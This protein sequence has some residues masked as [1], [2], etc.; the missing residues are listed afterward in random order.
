MTVAP[1]PPADT[2]WRKERR[3]FGELFDRFINSLLNW[4]FD[5]RPERAQRRMRNLFVLFLLTGFLICLYYY[6]P[7]LWAGYLQEVFSYLLN[8]N[9]AAAYAGEP[10]SK[11]FLFAFQAFTD[12][13]VFQYFPIILAPF[14]IALHLAALYLADIFELDDVAV[15]R[16]FVWEV[17]LSGSD[18][19]MRVRQGQVADE[20]R[21][22]SNYL[23]GGPGKVMVDLDSVALFERADGTPHVIGPTGKEPGGRATIEGFERFR[24][25]I[26]IRDHYVELRDQ[27]DRSKSVRGRSRDGIP[28]TAT[29]VRL[30]FSISRGENPQPSAEFPY[31]FAK[32]AIERIVYKSVSRVTPDQKEPSV[33]EF[34]WINN[35]IGLIRGRLSGFMSERNLTEYLASVGLPEIEKAK[36]REELIA[37]QVRRLT[38]PDEAP[39]VKPPEVPQFTPRHQ[40]TSLFSQFAEDFTKSAR[41]N[42]V[43]LHWIGVG[44]WKTP[45]EIDIVSEKHLQAWKLSQE[46]MKNGN[47]MTMN[48]AENQAMLEKME[49]LIHHVPIN[50]Y[51]EIVEAP[52]RQFYKKPLPKKFD[53]KQRDHDLDE[54][55]IFDDQ[56]MLDM[57]SGNYALT[58]L[59]RRVNERINEAAD[60]RSRD[61]G[62]DGD[63]RAAMRKLLFEYRKQLSEAVQFMKAKN[64]PV[65]AVI[66]EAIA[67][68][69]RQ[70]GIH[71]V[72]RARE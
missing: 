25:A 46:N 54:D 61:F 2:A 19:T 69:D 4:L 55:L 43:E 23:I 58:D 65:P 35:M 7:G 41:N 39:K 38:Q 37:E 50:A 62:R 21:E 49:S 11:F 31:P 3:L 40:V 30:M 5:L 16:S 71:W 70:S 44:T 6:R 18:E 29:D 12:P 8:P 66:E 42:G 28:I 63:Q 20:H 45:P 60:Q 64:E 17:A 32:E 72:R 1:Q 24:Q 36:E 47:Q 27:D 34:S 51:Q 67:Y 9:Y 15:A 26:D 33:Y 48:K 56:D 14:F 59:T 53:P 10:F 22:D 52:K 57:L 68:I 13:H